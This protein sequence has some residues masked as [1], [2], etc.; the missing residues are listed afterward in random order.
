MVIGLHGGGGD[1]RHV[2][3]KPSGTGDYVSL[4]VPNGDTSCTK[5]DMPEEVPGFMADVFLPMDSWQYELRL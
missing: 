4:L 3:R 2:V 5:V 1:G